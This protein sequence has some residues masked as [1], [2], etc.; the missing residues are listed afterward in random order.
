V[1]VWSRVLITKCLVGIYLRDLV[2]VKLA[3]RDVDRAAWRGSSCSSHIENG[4]GARRTAGSRCLSGRGVDYEMLGGDTFEIVKLATAVVETLVAR[5]SHSG[6]SCSSHID[7]GNRARHL[8]SSKCSFSPRS[9]W[10]KVC[11]VVP[12]GNLIENDSGTRGRGWSRCDNL[13]NCC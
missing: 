1:F 9:R 5:C 8:T 6:S 7:K 12:R 10:L 13:Q 3:S 4:D 11:G 2:I